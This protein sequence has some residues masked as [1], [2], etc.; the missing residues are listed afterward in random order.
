MSYYF[1]GEY[2]KATNALAEALKIE[3]TNS[4]ICNNFAL[5]LC[6]LG[7]Y[8]EALEMF[9]KGGDEAVA[10]NNIGYLYLIERKYD[11]AI[12][13]F[14]KAIELNPRFYIKAHENIKRAEAAVNN[15]S[16]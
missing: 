10:Y 1:S 7:R 5:A 16:K 2:E 12:K 13:S 11:E 14:E 15:Q 4:K 8:Q 3:G 9:K 6:K